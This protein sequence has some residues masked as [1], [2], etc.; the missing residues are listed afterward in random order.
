[1]VKISPSIL[2]AD[3]ANLGR[4]VLKLKSWGASFVHCDV[5]DGVFVPNITFG[6]QMIKSIKPYANLPL[7]VHLMIIGPERHIESFVEA[8]A[9]CI[10]VHQEA[11]KDPRGT[12]RMIK[13]TGIKAGV[14]LRPETDIKTL[15]NVLDIADIILIM[16]VNPGFGGQALIPAM[17]DKVAALKKIIDNE[18][19]KVE[20]SVDGGVTANNASSLVRAGAGILVAGTTVFKAVD[21]KG[22]IRDL[23]GN[24]IV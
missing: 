4:D 23:R 11:V 1:M 6:P 2:A 8:G 21:P 18:S 17:I 22:T 9:D 19:R 7:D 14:A 3:F 10:T 16:T 15:E 13:E 5:M 24:Q 12:L 20:I